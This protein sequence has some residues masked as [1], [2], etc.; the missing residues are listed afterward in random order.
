MR[1]PR[2]DK[3]GAM[4]RD[5][6]AILA[7]L[8]ALNLINYLD[9]AVIAAVLTPMKAQLG[10]TNFEAGVLN[11]AF[12]VGYFVTSPLFG[13]R[14]DK[15][16]RKRLIALGVVTW[17]LATVAS[18]FAVGFW[19][20]LVA[21]IVVG[22]GEASYLVLAPTI[23]DD[24]TPLDRKGTALSVFYAAIPVGYALGYILGGT[25]AKHWDAASGGGW[26]AGWQMAFFV[27]GGPGVV[28]ALSC[29][30]IVEPPRKLLHAKAKLLDGM[31]ELIAIPLYR[32]SVLGYCAYVGSVAGFSYW[33]ADFLLRA[34]PDEL[35]VGTAN[36]RLGGI[37]LVS[38]M[39]GTIVGGRFANRASRSHVP[40]PDEPY[41][42]PGNKRAVNGLLRICGVGM[43][44]AAPLSAVGFFLPGSNAYFTVSFFV[45]IGLFA[46]T[47]P[48]NAA[49]M[50][51]VP[52]ERRA[53][54]MAM[55]I[56]ASHLLGDLWSA[57]LLGLLLDTLPLKLAMLSLP[58]TFAWTAYIWW[59]RRREV[60]G[61]AA[62][63]PSDPA[64]PAARIHT[65]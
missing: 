41:D 59:P 52:T 30:L 64:L 5:R 37:L 8:T 6:R 42:S 45:Q 55:S 61:P 58:L 47:S 13:L 44:V 14:A 7:L 20:L 36:Q 3:L 34:F 57:A 22:V 9:R 38:G 56:F 35:D 54:A 39:I 43:A 23:I 11:T 65:T 53:S 24:V 2:N 26:P 16:T 60:S 46:T 63:A 19:S 31:R 15:G 50:R 51:A 25:I 4:I 29:L 49:F 17:S 40:A 18:G 12:L 28:L 62:G 1:Q 10:L 21:R 27:V 32:R 48:V 33:V